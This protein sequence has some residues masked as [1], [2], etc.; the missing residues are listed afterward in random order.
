MLKD[1]QLR[2]RQRIK[3]TLLPKNF[4]TE[5]KV[6]GRFKQKDLFHHL[7]EAS[8]K[9]FRSKPIILTQRNGRTASSCSCFLSNACIMIHTLLA[10]FNI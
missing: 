8:R 10:I 2:H 7:P 1:S 5:N 6:T 9:V 4:K 3:L